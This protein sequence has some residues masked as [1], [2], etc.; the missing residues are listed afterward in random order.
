VKIPRS[1]RAWLLIVCMVVISAANAF[2]LPRNYPF[3]GNNN[4]FNINSVIED[5]FW[6]EGAPVVLANHFD[7]VD[8]TNIGDRFKNGFGF[9]NELEVIFKIHKVDRSQDPVDV[10]GKIAMKTIKP[11]TRYKTTTH[12][13]GRN[14]KYCKL[15][16][17]WDGKNSAPYRT[18]VGA[19]VEDNTYALIDSNLLNNWLEAA[20]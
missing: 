15:I 18:F 9:Q 20:K 11:Y 17:V 3:Y 4:T 13:S 10:R 5:A 12:C 8:V 19:R 6:V 1:W 16:L 14:S 7:R 2:G